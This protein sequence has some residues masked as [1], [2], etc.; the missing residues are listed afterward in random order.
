MTDLEVRV[1]EAAKDHRRAVIRLSGHDHNESC[2]AN[3]MKICLIVNEF[4][5]TGWNLDKA[6][7]DL[8]ATHE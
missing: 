4:H 1:I 2:I 7:A 8:E 5:R 6:I 3:E